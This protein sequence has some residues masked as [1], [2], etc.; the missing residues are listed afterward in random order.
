MIGFSDS[1]ISIILQLASCSPPALPLASNWPASGCNTAAILPGDSPPALF[2]NPLLSDSEGAAAAACH[3]VFLPLFELPH[4]EQPVLDQAHANEN[5]RN[6]PRTDHTKAVMRSSPP[7]PGSCPPLLIETNRNA[8]PANH[9]GDSTFHSL[10][11]ISPTPGCKR[12]TW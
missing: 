1:N 9:H 10:P 11:H 4:H 6:P 2:I 12:Q 3:A 5:S 7:N 8:F